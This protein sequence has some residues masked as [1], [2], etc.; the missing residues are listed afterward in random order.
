MTLQIKPGTYVAAV[1]GG[2]DSM[3]LLDML[4]HQP[5]LQIIVAHFNHGTRTDNA[6]DAALV[7][8]AAAKYGLPYIYEEGKLGAD[9]SE[10]A[11]REARYDFLQHV[12]KMQ[13]AQGIILAHHEDDVLET[14][15]LNLIRGTGRKGLSSLQSHAHRLRPLLHMTK[16]EILEYA[17]EHQIVW[18]E[19][20][21]NQD[22]KY[23]RNYIRHAVMSGITEA[24]RQKLRT[25]YKQSQSVNAALDE[26]LTLVLDTI[27]GDEGMERQSFIQLPHAIS[28]EVM[29]T[30]LREQHVNNLDRKQIER[31]VTAAKTAQPGTIYDVDKRKIMNISRNFL[32]I[33]SRYSRNTTV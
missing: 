2:V 26:E 9:I 20:S 6:E 21:T 5:G 17:K 8:T 7:A 32:E 4:A 18:R 15:L 29:A 33:T 11:A 30:W 16:K 28:R 24:Q 14:M 23:K 1:S 27:V 10:L 13:N 12:Q 3:V 22:M 25:I 31:L 19:D